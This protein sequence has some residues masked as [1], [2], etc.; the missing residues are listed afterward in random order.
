MQRLIPGR[1]DFGVSTLALSWL[2]SYLL[3]RK[4]RVIIEQQQSEY[5]DLLTSVPQGSCLGPILFIMDAFPMFQV[6]KKH[7]LSV[8]GYAD[9]T[10][11][12]LSF[13]AGF[14]S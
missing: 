14:P 5:F 6:P 2:K 10:Q 1:F 9:N 4:P 7:L 3:G 11:L 12:Y 13:R 8:H